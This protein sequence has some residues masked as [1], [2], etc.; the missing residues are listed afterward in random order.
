MLAK[1]EKQ[2]KREQEYVRVRFRGDGPLGVVDC[3]ASFESQHHPPKAE[4]GVGCCIW[5]FGEADRK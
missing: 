4:G 1:S 3:G 5:T 2:R